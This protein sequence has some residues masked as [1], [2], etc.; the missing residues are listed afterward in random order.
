[1][2]LKERIRLYRQD[3]NL[4]QEEL[5]KLLY[6]SRSSIAKWE[7][8]R[9]LPSLDLLVQM[10]KLFNLSID[11][12]INDVDTK[13]L[14]ILNNEKIAKNH[15]IQIISIAIVTCFLLGITGL[16]IGVLNKKPTEDTIQYSYNCVKVI[17]KSDTEIVLL[18]NS[19][20]EYKYTQEEVSKISIYDRYNKIT[21]YESIKIENYLELKYAKESLMEIKITETKTD[22]YKLKGF[23]LTFSDAELNEVPI[24]DEMGYGYN[25]YDERIQVTDDIDFNPSF[26]Y[27]FFLCDTNKWG[28]SSFIGT[29]SAYIKTINNE[30]SWGILSKTF[31]FNVNTYDSENSLYVYVVDNSSK[32]FYLY[33]EILPHKNKNITISGSSINSENNKENYANPYS[34]DLEFN[35]NI[36]RVD[37]AIDEVIV[38]EYGKNHNLINEF[39][40][41]SELDF[42]QKNHHLKV[43]ND[44]TL[45]AL[46]VCKAQN[47]T[48]ETYWLPI[49]NGVEFNIN[50][51]FGFIRQFVFSF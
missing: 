48:V 23:F 50:N 10:A 18:D 36:K 13:S 12:L 4:T 3:N 2:E 15:R 11:D 46:V 43:A 19:K 30:V 47:V 39:S 14:V 8:G 34:H 45:Y 35:I 16:L 51:G 44:D 7:Q 38:L 26:K 9:S 1:M 6:V 17:N 31:N 33:D 27:P 29:P 49:G 37:P 20:N 24:R 42:Y 41:N 28:V 40:F 32:G 5:A 25:T 22:N 21:D